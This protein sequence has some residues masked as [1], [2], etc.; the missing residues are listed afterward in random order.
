MTIG[1]KMEKLIVTDVDGTLVPDGGVEI[2]RKYFDVIR[3]LTE[4]EFEFVIASGRHST[5][6]KK[7]FDPVRDCVWFLSQNG[8]MIEKGNEVI[9]PNNIPYE[10]AQELWS[11]VKGSVPTGCII[12]T[13]KHAY[14]HKDCKELT[15]ILADIYRYD[16]VPCESSNEIPQNEKITMMT[17]YDPKDCYAWCSSHLARKWW[18]RLQIL[19][20]GDIW[21]DI[22]HPK[23]G[24]GRALEK[25][26]SILNI[27][28]ENVTAFGDN[29]NDI[30]MFK[31]AGNSIA[32]NNA[33]EDVKMAADR[34]IKGYKDDGV[35]KELENM[36]EYIADLR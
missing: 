30:S 27:K 14:L 35:L 10:W 2:N 1:A 13:A 32:V 9:I 19:K 8:G 6:L 15:S 28:R 25:L 23:N 29:M 5:N 20:T 24:K 33:V 31:F 4:R 36:L 18:D 16:V 17:M 11:E 12:Y 34:V 26:C 22:V 21:V 7:M 3:K